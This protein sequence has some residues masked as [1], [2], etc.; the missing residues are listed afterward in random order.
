MENAIGGQTKQSN[1]IFKVS[2]Q[3]TLYFAFIG[4]KKNESS[5]GH[6]RRKLHIS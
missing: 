5:N 6:P 2:E 1:R 4:G 3:N